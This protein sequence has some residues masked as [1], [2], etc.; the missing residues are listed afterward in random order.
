[1]CPG[2]FAVISSFDCREVVL[3]SN[4]CVLNYTQMCTNTHEKNWLQSSFSL[5]INYTPH[6]NHISERHG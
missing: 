2:V 4:T 6:L 5:F 1:M 3:D